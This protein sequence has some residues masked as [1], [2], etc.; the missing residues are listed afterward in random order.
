MW[1]AAVLSGGV[2]ACTVALTAMGTE[3]GAACR[4]ALIP[5]YLP[6]SSVAQLAERPVP[7][8]IAILN[9]SNGPGSEAQ[10]DHRRAVDALRGS[11]TRV[12]G[13][14]HTQYG[15]RDL[16]AVLADIGRYETWYGLDGVFLDEAAED[17]AQLPF[18]AAVSAE[19]RASGM[20]LVALNPGVVPAPGYFDVGDIVVTFE[21]PFGE[22]AAALRAMPKWLHELPPR[23]S[24]HLVYGAGHEQALEAVRASTA[25][26]FY[27]TSG[28]LPNP[29]S[30][31]PA[32][33]AD[34]ETQLETCR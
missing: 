26:Y 7:R 5:A 14:V 27:A 12:L 11:G 3:S 10:P 28:S 17:A 20:R 15:A 25:G 29:W 30:P 1:L 19:A 33:L 32:Y 34:L 21:G 24:A 16:A 13:Y 18:Y 8:R 2:A 23:Q 4:S 6:A 31:L 9:P 22:Y